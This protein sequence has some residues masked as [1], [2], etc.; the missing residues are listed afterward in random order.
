MPPGWPVPQALS[1]SSA[2]DPHLAACVKL[3]LHHQI[4]Q[5]ALGSDTRGLRLDR[6]LAV[7]GLAGVLRV[8][9]ELVER[10]ENRRAIFDGREGVRIRG[11]GLDLHGLGLERSAALQPCPSARPGGARCKGGRDGG[12]S[13]GLHKWIEAIGESGKH[14]FARK[15]G[16]PSRPSVSDP[17]RHA[18]GQSP[19]AVGHVDSEQFVFQQF[20]QPVPEDLEATGEMLAV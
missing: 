20:F 6:C 17:L 11:H 9:F 19:Q 13:P 15:D 12:G 10:D 8:L 4:L 1:R 2:S 18:R 5:D 14:V 16:R 3:R 7:W